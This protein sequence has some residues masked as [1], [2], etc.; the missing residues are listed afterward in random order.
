MTLELIDQLL[1]LGSNIS[2]TE[3]D[4][5]MCIG[6]VWSTIEKWSTI[7]KSYQSKKQKQKLN[8]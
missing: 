4:V 3:C 7:L 8:Q 5:N 6:K 2:S 1:Y